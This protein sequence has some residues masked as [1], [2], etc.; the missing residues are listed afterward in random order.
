MTKPPTTAWA[1]AALI[2]GILAAPLIS[3]GCAAVALTKTKSGQFGGRGLAIAGLILS[4]I[5]IVIGVFA[6]ALLVF[7]VDDSTDNAY[8]PSAGTCFASAPDSDLDKNDEVSCDQ[9]HRA[10]VFAVFTVPGDTFPGDDAMKKYISR[11]ENEFAK[12]ASADE[13]AGGIDIDD[14]RPT[15]QSWIQGDRT[16]TCLAVAQDR[17]VTGSLHG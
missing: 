7:F 9:P 10:E 2:F 6:I 11:C 3:I 15:D 4:G 14:L 16:V 5:W 1:I 8:T 13:D 12:Y 17:D